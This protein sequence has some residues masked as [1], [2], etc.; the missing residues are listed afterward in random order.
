MLNLVNSENIPFTFSLDKSTYEASKERIESTG[1]QPVVQFDPPSGTVMA[2]SS[3]PIKVETSPTSQI[4][5]Y[6]IE[7]YTN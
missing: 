6:E 3:L 4:S 1:Q 7:P 2:N 5:L